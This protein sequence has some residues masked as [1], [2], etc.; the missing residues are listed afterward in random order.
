M[1]SVLLMCLMLASCASPRRTPSPSKATSRP[2]KIKGRWYYPQK[3]YE[4][5][6][7]GMASYYGRGHGAHGLPTAT[8]ERFCRYQ[9]TAA[10]KTL[11][12]PCVARVTNLENGRQVVLRINDRGPFIRKRILD[13]S[14]AAAKELGFYHQG[15]ARVR[16]E[17]LVAESM[18]LPEN[19]PGGVRKRKSKRCGRPR[20]QRC[21]GYPARK[22]ARRRKPRRSLLR[23]TSHK[24]RHISDLLS[25]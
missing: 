6:E 13:V 8:G 18:A 21:K 1:G 5:T 11:P 12:L 7:T 19:R 25:F 17:T 15:L 9:M 16:L 2:Y 24:P 14:S 4:L 10:H 20:H 23:K 3:H 22:P